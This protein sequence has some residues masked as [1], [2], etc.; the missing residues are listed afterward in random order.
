MNTEAV[1]TTRPGLGNVGQVAWLTHDIESQIDSWS[2]LAGVGPWVHYRNL[3][4][5]AFYKGENTEV[6]MDV[7]LAYRGD[8][9]IELIQQHNDAPSPYR[10]YFSS[11]HTGIHHV[12]IMVEDFDA[13]L[14]AAQAAGFEMLFWGGEK[15]T[16]RFAYLVHPAM[17][18]VLQ[19]L[20]E[21]SELMKA[22]WGDLR[23]QAESWNGEKTVQTI[24]F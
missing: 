20:L 3:K 24:D 5:N 14:A 15:E 2:R 18:G 17:P 10:E 1:N 9:Q 4:V 23:L 16:G 13:T 8:M 7:A 12:G 21:L 19:E 11:G 6:H 22:M